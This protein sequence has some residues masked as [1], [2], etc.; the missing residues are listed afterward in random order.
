MPLVVYFVIFLPSILK[1]SARYCH[2][3][4]SRCFGSSPE[5]AIS[6]GRPGNLK[7]E[8]QR[9]MKVVKTSPNTGDQDRSP[10]ISAEVQ[11]NA[12]DGP[13]PNIMASA[14][15]A[16]EPESPD[17]T[18]TLSESHIQN[19]ER[20][21]MHHG[22]CQHN[23]SVELN[24]M[25]P[26]VTP[27]E[28]L[29]TPTTNSEYANH[30]DDSTSEDRYSSHSAVPST[31]PPTYHTALTN[32]S[33]STLPLYRENEDDPLSRASSARSALTS[34]EYSTRRATLPSLPPL[35]DPVQKI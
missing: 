18:I 29:G 16:V 2:R 5:S 1:T 7:T 17:F 8:H 6:S 35:P 24:D 34:G 31:R 20:N 19:Q 3:N 12:L 10:T 21:E 25:V 30:F 26:P 28:P 13:T 11:D 22:A 15:A 4:L 27:I 23:G 14:T 32:A 33:I 9:S